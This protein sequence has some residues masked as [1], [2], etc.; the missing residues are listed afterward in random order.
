MKNIF[1]RTT[2]LIMIGLIFINLFVM[3]SGI[4]ISD[5]INILEQKTDKLHK[6]NLSLEKEVANLSSLKFAAEQA[7]EFD[8]SNSS[9]PQYIDQLK[10]AYR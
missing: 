1:L 3:I 8:F 7:K 9:A 5:E 6:I 4:V 10:Y 2:G